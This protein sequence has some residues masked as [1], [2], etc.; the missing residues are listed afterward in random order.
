[1]KLR[2]ACRSLVVGQCCIGFLL[3]P[4]L[5]LAAPICET[6]GQRRDPA[7]VTFLEESGNDLLVELTVDPGID[8][9][10]VTLWHDESTVL[11]ATSAPVSADGFASVVMSGV[12]AGSET[13]EIRYHLAVVLNELGRADEARRQLEQALEDGRDFASRTA[14]QALQSTLATSTP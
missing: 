3:A 1:M 14:A 11:A 7:V 8:P 13:R 2:N 4:G 5:A 9:V 12:L 6:Q 10:V